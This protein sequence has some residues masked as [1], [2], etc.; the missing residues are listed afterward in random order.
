M[1][2]PLG[3]DTNNLFSVPCLI[4]ARHQISQSEN[5]MNQVNRPLNF[6]ECRVFFLG[7][8]TNASVN[9][10]STAL[11]LASS[12]SWFSAMYPSARRVSAM[13]LRHPQRHYSK[14]R[15]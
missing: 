12:D 5:I 14:G 8:L 2:L 9:R 11:A 3:W 15:C 4:T 10:P 6:D 13:G 1:T 7:Q